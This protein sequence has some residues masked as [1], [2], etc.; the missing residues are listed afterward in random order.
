M[1]Y[2]VYSGL[3][4]KI[5]IVLYI[6]MGYQGG[7][8]RLGKRIHQK[9]LELERQIYGKDSTLDYF[10]PFVGMCGVMKHFG[11][12]K[13]DRKLTA[14][15]YN[16]DVI[17][18]LQA[19]QKGW[20]PPTTC[21]EEIFLEMKSSTEHSPE[22]GFIGTQLS[23]SGIFFK[24]YRGKY[25]KGKFDI[26]AQGT[27]CVMKIKDDI[28]G[29]D[30]E[31]ARSYES[32]S[33]KGKLIYCD[34]P[35]KGNHLGMKGSLFQTFDHA[36]FWETMRLWSKDN[37]VVISESSAPDDFE[38]IQCFESSVN[39]SRGKIKIYQEFL[40]VH[41]DTISQLTNWKQSP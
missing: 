21:S 2:S 14:C 1:D 25:T 11:R 38:K 17:L 31:D 10:E 26:L 8:A 9:L 16:T 20:L 22:R 24:D 28:L 12:E 7:K 15:D 32:F 34:P 27:R 5:N 41:R 29:V 13:G 35:Y 6:K 33:P 36:T 30:F 18:M 3:N 37:L 4:K 39:V 23:W 40:Y 19:L